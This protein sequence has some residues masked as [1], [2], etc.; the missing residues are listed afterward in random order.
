MAY[1]VTFL[2]GTAAAYEALVSPNANTFYYTTDD[3]QFY[4]GAIK[5]S[6]AGDVTAALSRIA[7]NES[8]ISALEDA[9]DL[10]NSDD[11]TA[12]SVAKQIKDAVDALNNSL[13]DVATS[14]AAADVS[15]KDEQEVFTSTN[16][17]DTLFEL[18]GMID[19]GGTGSVV[20]VREKTTPTAGYLKSYEILQGQTVKGVIDIPKDLV[21][22]S[23][24][25]VKDPA[26][27]PAGTYLKL[28]IANQD[29]PVY[30]NVADLVDVY[31]AEAGATQVQL[32]IS[33]TN[34][35]SATIVAG[36]VG[37][38]ELAANAVTTAKIA[39]GNV[40]KV[41]L[42]QAVQDS[43]DLADSS[44][45][46]VVEGNTNGTISVDGTEVSVHGLGSAAYADTTDFDEAG[47]AADVLGT[48][49]DDATA[50]TVYGAKAAA[51]AAQGTADQAILDAAAAQAD[52]DAL[53]ALVG[54]TSV[55]SQIT[56][57]IGA[58]DYTDT[59][60]ADQ[61]VSAVSETDGIISVTRTSLPDYS[62]TYDAK[63]DAAAAETAAKAYTDQA[64][65]WGTF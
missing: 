63:G 55:T 44:V 46:S 29:T 49:A 27:Q 1:N 18:Y 2:K 25:V 26:G 9:V 13:A 11:T 51:G 60:V 12:G 8:A 31:T 16:V 38:T 52:V 50:N 58:L 41:K 64:L 28:T 53:Q 39:D 4:L 42:A 35:I 48:A 57:A 40:T 32:A 33:S 30:I 20:T 65:T 62:N 22:T 10:L 3:S 43:L 61:Y 24:Q 15:I 23:G 5:L 21:I 54:N 17:E 36:S 47:A 6:N 34:E 45:Q 19:S 37:T 7:A 56:A 59:A 14:G